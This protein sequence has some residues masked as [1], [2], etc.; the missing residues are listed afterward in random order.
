M[1]SCV[2]QENK[3]NNKANVYLMSD[4]KDNS[5]KIGEGGNPFK[6]MNDLQ[7]GNPNPL[8]IIGV[9][10]CKSKKEAQNKESRLHKKYEANRKYWHGKPSEWFENKESSK[11]TIKDIKEE[12]ENDFVSIV[13]E[14]NRES[15]T[16]I[17]LYGEEEIIVGSADG[18]P[19]CYFYPDQFA[20]IIKSYEA[21]I[22]S[23]IKHRTMSYPTNGKQLLLPYSDETDRVFISQ[24]KHMENIQLNNFNK[25]DSN[26]LDDFITTGA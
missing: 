1:N 15:L 17:N 14:S 13:N 22:N 24:R 6:R 12:F 19:I 23:K 5:V 7:T 9:I 26:S 20:Q 18:R 3:I 4:E 25:I 8:K 11:L 16:T 10:P 2:I 21:S